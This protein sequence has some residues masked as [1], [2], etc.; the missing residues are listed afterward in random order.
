[1]SLLLEQTGQNTFSQYPYCDK[2]KT[3]VCL[4]S[5][6]PR[7]VRLVPKTFQNQIKQRV[8]K[9]V[10]N[11]KITFNENC[12]PNWLLNTMLLMAVLKYVTI[13]SHVV[14]KP[15]TIFITHGLF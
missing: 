6:A 2:T 9:I 11:F 8:M 13:C 5:L 14:L 15:V 12:A 7:A 4:H 1:M 10:T 3:D